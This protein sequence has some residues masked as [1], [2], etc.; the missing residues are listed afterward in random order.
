M[1]LYPNLCGSM[2]CSPPG[3][4]CSWISQAK[5]LKWVAISF[6]RDQTHVSCVFCL[7]GRFFTT[8]PPGKLKNT[9]VGC[10]SLLQ[11]VFL[12][13]GSNPG[14]LYSRRILYRLSHQRSLKHRQKNQESTRTFM[15]LFPHKG[16]SQALL[17]NEL[18]AVY[19]KEGRW[20]P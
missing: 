8:K 18:W 1:E 13:Q 3:S 9:A 6:S 11:R 4:F 2:D 19:Q 12:T 10:H 16:A 20:F 5:I 17:P 7:A 14:L 15:H